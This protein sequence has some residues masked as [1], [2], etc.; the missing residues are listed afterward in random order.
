[1]VLQRTLK[2]HTL[3]AKSILFCYQCSAL[4]WPCCTV[5]ASHTCNVNLILRFPLTKL[6]RKNV[7]ELKWIPFEAWDLLFLLSHHIYSL[8]CQSSSALGIVPGKCW[9]QEM[10][11][12]SVVSLVLGKPT[13]LKSANYAYSVKIQLSCLSLHLAKYFINNYKKFRDG[14]LLSLDQT[15]LVTIVFCPLIHELFWFASFVV[16]FPVWLAV[17]M[18]DLLLQRL[19]Q[20]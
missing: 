12:C 14:H 16:M 3:F 2:T 1:M 7:S 6:S 20:W 8:N 17:H 19:S 13:S 15:I 10:T 18:R 4:C 5:G 9:G 11:Y